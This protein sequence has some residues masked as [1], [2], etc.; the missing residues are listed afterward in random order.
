MSVHFWG[1]NPKGTWKVHARNND[2]DS[3]CKATRGVT[4]GDMKLIL[5]GTKDEPSVVGLEPKQQNAIN[6]SLNESEDMLDEK[7]DSL[8]GKCLE[9]QNVELNGETSWNELV[10]GKF[11]VREDNNRF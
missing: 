3:Q 1:E 6:R 9:Q 7:P 5:Y 2:F 10:G 8:L 4:F 11:H